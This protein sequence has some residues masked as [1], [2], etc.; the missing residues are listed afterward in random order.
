[1][2][3]YKI[4]LMNPYDT[5]EEIGNRPLARCFQKTGVSYFIED[6]NPF[7][8]AYVDE[9]LFI[10]EL[11]TTEFLRKSNICNKPYSES[12][13]VL[14]FNDLVRFKAVPITKEE[15]YNL[16]P[17]G[18]N[19][20]FVKAIEKAIFNRDNDFELSTMEELSEDRYVQLS[21]YQDGLT[22]IDPYSDRYIDMKA[23]RHRR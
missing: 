21:A 14:K 19:K 22:T 8:I 20:L 3:F 16:L 9:G 17:L 6:C 18:A 23:L 1:M 15:L 4:Y 12:E 13:D 10:R 5:E 2:L 11:F 7:I